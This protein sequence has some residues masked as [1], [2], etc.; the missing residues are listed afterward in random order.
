MSML[1]PP[2]E[3]AARE[4]R[5]IGS[6]KITDRSGRDLDLRPSVENGRRIWNLTNAAGS[7]SGVSE[8]EVQ[9]CLPG[10]DETLV[11]VAQAVMRGMAPERMI[12]AERLRE[13]VPALKW[14]IDLT[15]EAGGAEES[16][17]LDELLTVVRMRL[18]D[19]ADAE[20]RA[21]D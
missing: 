15:R 7:L 12:A 13:Y 8:E 17:L 14:A 6:Y 3:R 1:T 4:L 18:A 9:W 20:A 16:A 2:Y 5:K 21:A 11:E 19:I 10:D